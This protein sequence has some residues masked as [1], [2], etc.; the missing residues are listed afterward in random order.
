MKLLVS[1]GVVTLF[2]ATACEWTDI[3]VPVI[4]ETGAVFTM[5]NAASGNFVIVFARAEDGSLTRLDSIATGGLGSGPDP[6]FGTD[7]LQSQDALILSADNKLLFAVN[8][9][10][11]DV[12]SF[13]VNTDG[14]LTR[15]SIISSGG[16]FPVSLAHH[17]NVLYVV[18]ARSGG[19]ILGFRVTNDGALQAIAASSQPLSGAVDPAPASIR[20]SP[21]GARI[22]VTEKTTNIL[23]IF[24]LDVAGVAGTRTI[25]NSPGMTPFG[26]DFDSDGLYILAEAHINPGRTA[27]PNAST[28]SSLFV[29]E[30]AFNAPALDVITA[31][32]P[33]T[34]T[35]GSRTQIISNNLAVYI[36]NTVSATITGFRINR[37]GSL[38]I[39]TADGK[40]AQLPA[41]SQ[42]TDMAFANGFLYAITPGDRSLNIFKVNSDGSLTVQAG[43][44]G[45]FPISVTGLAAF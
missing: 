16:T 24:P 43:L 45:I 32:A 38:T 7:P 44:A 35:A 22:I 28:V 42:P 30:D 18:N 3:A 10:S 1:V 4:T 15:V 25:A 21:D 2:C 8:A 12:T 27:V 36:T 31:S 19:R 37:N 39:L 33:T 26:A 40:A 14:T 23:D 29:S 41:A 6:T 13:R 11:N 34:Q 17:R 9:G 5:N 20:I